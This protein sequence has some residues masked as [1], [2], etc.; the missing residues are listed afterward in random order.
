MFDLGGQRW[1]TDVPDVKR[2][3]GNHRR[4]VLGRSLWRAQPPRN[5]HPCR[6]VP[7][8][9]SGERTFLGGFGHWIHQ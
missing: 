9:D 7:T 2:S 1:S 5:V 8:V 6:Q 3:L 4:G